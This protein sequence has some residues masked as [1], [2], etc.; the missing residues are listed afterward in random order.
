MSSVRLRA[1]ELPRE[2]EAALL[3][4]FAYLAEGSDDAKRFARAFSPGGGHTWWERSRPAGHLGRAAEA[5][6]HERRGE[7]SE[8]L[9]LYRSLSRARAPWVRL[10]GVLLQ[11]WS[12]EVPE[13]EP[14]HRAADWVRTLRASA[15]KARLL[16]KL[17]GFSADKGEREYAHTLWQEAVAASDPKT[18][19]GRALRI[20][21]TNLG[22]PVS[23]VRFEPSRGEAPDALVFPEEIEALQLQSANQALTRNVEDQISSTWQETIRM[24]N[25]PLAALDSAEAQARWIGLPWLRRPI[26]KQLG[27]QLLTGGALGAGQWTHGVIN[28]TLGSGT[29]YDMAL[30]FA[31]PHFEDDSADDI[32]SAIADCDPTRGRGQRVATLAAEAWDLLSEEMLRR[33]VAEIPPSLGPASP[34]TES[35]IVW[36]AYALRLTEE[37]F[38]RYRGL[39][40]T[41][42]AALLDTIDPSAI[43]HF[44]DE[45]RKMMYRALGDDDRLLAENGRLL[46]FAAVLAPRRESDRLRRLI[47][48]PRPK[49]AR[50]I[51]RL[52]T[53]RPELT[54]AAVEAR[55]LSDL[56]RNLSKQSA[57]ARRGKTA[58]GGVGPRIELGRFLSVCEKPDRP[59]I[60]LLVEAAIDPSLPS[61]YLREARQGLVLLRRAGRLSTRNLRALRAAP[62]SDSLS[63]HPEGA[64]PTLLRASLLFICAERSTASE[65]TELVAMARSPEERVRVI[66]VNACA[67]ALMQTHDDGLAWAVVSGLFDPSPSVCE[68]A[69]TGLPALHLGYPAAAEVAWQRLPALFAASTR[70]VRTVIIRALGATSTRGSRHRRQRAEL[71]RWAQLDRSWR[72]RDAASQVGK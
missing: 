17:A 23:E 29:H 33:M 39:D 31:E 24:G 14:I 53:E 50:V 47:E 51:S 43:G 38:A 12:A 13:T 16:A 26:Q 65:R 37:W 5:V 46:P 6:S 40:P 15:R 59:A 48:D 60:D 19:L 25:G 27:A 8:A 63:P 67:E 18:H 68:A 64:S 10:L 3:G 66:A 61:H 56:V 70:D 54:S 30:R 34:A 35:R 57:E 41:V 62:E 44:D 58:F 20:E 21:A 2:L 28:W 22:L 72:V 71:L 32:L 4:D 49:S 42:Q 1:V 7:R 55:T 11:C 45:M 36:A 52:R 9:E 69:L